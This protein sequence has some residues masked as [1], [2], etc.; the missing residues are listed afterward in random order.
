MTMFTRST[1]QTLVI[2]GVRSKNGGAPPG[3][4]ADSAGCVTPRYLVLA[5]PRQPGGSLCILYLLN[6][7]TPRWKPTCPSKRKSRSLQV[8]IRW[9]LGHYSGR[10]LDTSK[11]RPH[12][13]G[14]LS[15]TTSTKVPHDTFT[16][17]LHR[18][19]AEHD[20]TNLSHRQR[21][22]SQASLSHATMQPWLPTACLTPSTT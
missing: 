20:T 21:P 22:V 10:V 1:Q 16:P 3:P 14:W 8:P 11:S 17:T 7:A 5:Q 2:D 12:L 18:S 6:P 4:Q 9:Y 13:R 15:T 19:L